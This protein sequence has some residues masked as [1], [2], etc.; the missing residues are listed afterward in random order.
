MIEELQ[1]EIDELNKK[2]KDAGYDLKVSWKDEYGGTQSASTNLDIEV[3]CGC[4]KRYRSKHPTLTYPEES[5]CPKHKIPDSNCESCDLTPW[6]ILG[7]TE[8]DYRKEVEKA[9]ASGILTCKKCNFRQY[10]NHDN[11][12]KCGTFLKTLPYSISSK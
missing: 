8:K 1:K 4:D 6:N 11:C 5:C 7:I 12:V 10:N 2:I 9:K 3:I